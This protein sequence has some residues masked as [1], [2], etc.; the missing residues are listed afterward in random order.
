MDGQITLSE[1]I[2]D[3]TVDKHGRLKPAP[4]WYPSERCE[5]CIN[6]S[7]SPKQPAD[8]WGIYGPCTSHRHMGHEVSK[9]S[10]CDDFVRR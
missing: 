9:T 7:L 5:L 3:M 10:Y 6:W 1:Y 2:A 4:E 8:G